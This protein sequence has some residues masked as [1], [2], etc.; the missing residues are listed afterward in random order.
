M[1]VFDVRAE[2]G[3]LHAFEVENTWLSRKGVARIVGSIPGVRI[4]RAKSSWFSRDDFCEFEV[5]GVRFVAEEPFG[6]NSR[7]WIRPLDALHDA[8]LA[9]VRERFLAV[10]RPEWISTRLFAAVL[11]IYLGL[12]WV[13]RWP[14]TQPGGIAWLAALG[15]VLFVVGSI[16]A[17]SWALALK[18]GHYRSRPVEGVSASKRTG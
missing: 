14:E 9:I 15:A 16:I 2:D 13:R 8:E 7:Y 6:D 17:V 1:R 10:R 4:S 18:R 3:K 11:M 5:N 12:S